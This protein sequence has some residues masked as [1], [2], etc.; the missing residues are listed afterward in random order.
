MS[1][2][3]KL[4]LHNI[5]SGATL[6]SSSGTWALNR[7]VTQELELLQWFFWK[8]LLGFT[9][10]DHQTNSDIRER[11]KFTNIV[12]RVQ[13]YQKKKSAEII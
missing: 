8:S 2:D 6:N 5:L 1:I 12:E 4:H 11:F 7:K 13:V 3:P 10:L 9:R